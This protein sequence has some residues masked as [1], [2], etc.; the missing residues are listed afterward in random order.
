MRIYRGVSFN[1]QNELDNYVKNIR[2]GVEVRESSEKT[3]A[4]GKGLYFTANKSEAQDYVTRRKLENNHK[5][6]TVISFEI[7]NSN[8]ISYYDLSL[9]QSNES[10]ELM[11]QALSENNQS[12]GKKADNLRNMD[13]GEYAK[14]KGYNAIDVGDG[15]I[16]VVNQ[17]ILS[18]R[19]IGNTS[20]SGTWR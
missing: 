10:K 12:L 3:S 17:K 18:T 15:T 13:K 11:E 19:G 5:F 1:T 8:I 6:G 7:D 9:Q 20:I 2:K 14:M 16:V 4:S